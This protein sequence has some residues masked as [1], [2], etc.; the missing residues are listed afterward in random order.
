ME[1]GSDSSVIQGNKLAKDKQSQDHV[2][3]IQGFKNQK[4]GNNKGDLNEILVIDPKRRRIEKPN[5]HGPEV[6]T[7]QKD[8]SDM[9]NFENSMRDPK[10]GLGPG[11][12]RQAA[13][14]H[15]CY[16]LELSRFG[17]TL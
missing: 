6:M 4:A 9:D 5:L 14:H 13:S 10:N 2:M 3:K 1:R 16:K 7:G 11:A 15:E 17:P 8:D 12:A